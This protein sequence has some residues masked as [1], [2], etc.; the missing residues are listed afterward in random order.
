VSGIGT[1]AVDV[2][3][4]GRKT[5]VVERFPVAGHLGAHRPLELSYTPSVH[6]TGG[7]LQAMADGRRGSSDF[8]D[9]AWQAVQGQDMVI[10]LDLG[11]PKTLE[12]VQVQCYL[13]QDAWI[14]SPSEVR[15]EVSEDG[16]AFDALGRSKFEGALEPD[17]RQTV[18]PFAME[19][20][21]VQARFVRLTLVNA[22]ACPSWH[23]ATTEP[24]WLFAD[25]LVVLGR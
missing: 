10:T 14:F 17:A 19:G 20:A 23:D 2:A 4:R 22:G 15:W 9:G 18:V 7:S 1:V 12:V 16:D 25:E 6:Y 11:E 5:G 3:M 13:Y 21:G 8:R 24:S